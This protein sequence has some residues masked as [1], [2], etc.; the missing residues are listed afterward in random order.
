[1]QIGGSNKIIV[2]GDT[3]HSGSPSRRG[4]VNVFSS[5]A[6]SLDWAGGVDFT[7][8]SYYAQGNLACMDDSGNVY[9]SGRPGG[10]G[11]IGHY[12]CRFPSGG[13]SLDWSDNYYEVYPN[14]PLCRAMIT[15]STDLLQ[16]G[17]GGNPG[18]GVSAF[19][20][21]KACSNGNWNWHYLLRIGSGSGNN[22]WTKGITF[23]P[24][25]NSIIASGI[26]YSANRL[27]VMQIP[28]SGITVQT[29]GS[30]SDA[31]NFTNASRTSS[32]APIYNSPYSPTISNEGLTDKTDLRL[33]N[34]A[35]TGTFV[36]TLVDLSQ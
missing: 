12:T 6:S 1:M 18:V 32:T 21:S 4:M 19:I 5:N 15:D 31:W 30:G 27:W 25:G 14:S 9:H 29:Y 36:E 35:A 16:C 3:E 34:I 23:T 17:Y 7:N 13:G 2:G 8:S 20:S 28:K 24:S 33:N 26:E 10:S 11:L 22:S